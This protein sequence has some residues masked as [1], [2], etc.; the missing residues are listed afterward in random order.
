ML[1]EFEPTIICPEFRIYLEQDAETTDVRLTDGAV[2]VWLGSGDE[3]TISRPS[4]AGSTEADD[5]DEV[6]RSGRTSRHP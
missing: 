6:R 3:V 1:Y 5:V 4:S 2:I